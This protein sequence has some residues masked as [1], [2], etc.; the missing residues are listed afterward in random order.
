MLNNGDILDICICEKK[1]IQTNFDRKIKHHSEAYEVEEERI[2]PIV[3]TTS[4]E[5]H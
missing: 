1:Y 2:K 4:Y 5:V 3:F